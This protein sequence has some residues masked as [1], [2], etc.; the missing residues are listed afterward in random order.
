MKRCAIYTRV[1]TDMQAL[2]GESLD[3]Q[4]QRLKNYCNMRE[5]KVQKVY[6][7]E[8]KSGKNL[9]RPQF[10]E[11]IKDIVKG[12]IDTVVIKKIDRLSRSIID[13]EK[14]YMFF[15]ERGITL[16]SL[17]DNFDSSTA[18]GRAITRVVLVFAQLEREQTAERVSDVMQYRASK[19]M[20]N[21]GCVPYGYMSKD[22]K[23]VPDKKK[24][25]L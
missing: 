22:K 12:K 1:S 4:E 9:E 7:E 21:G 6:R 10:T 23:L 25:R 20:W 11:L 2:E 17:Q 13:F 24:V 19:G 8:G 5:L 15:E 3:E 14:T 18:I 16:I